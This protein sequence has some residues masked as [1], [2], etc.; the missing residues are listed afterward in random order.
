MAR[1]EG[2]FLSFGYVGLRIGIDVQMDEGMGGGTIFNY[3]G[4]GLAFL[5]MGFR[6]IKLGIFMLL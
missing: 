2:V 1:V 4:L 6:A 5:C 3:V